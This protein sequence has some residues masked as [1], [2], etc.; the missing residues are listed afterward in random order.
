MFSLNLT[1]ESSL[2]GK[3]YLKLIEIT[4]TSLLSGNTILSDYMSYANTH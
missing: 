3:I 4:C 2:N 1:F